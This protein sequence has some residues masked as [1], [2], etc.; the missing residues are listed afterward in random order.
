M[1]N[2][3]FLTFLENYV[4]FVCSKSALLLRHCFWYIELVVPKL[5]SLADPI[6]YLKLGKFEQ[7]VLKNCKC[8]VIGCLK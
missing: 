7:S 6:K 4:G 2:A 8:S 3:C 5:S 1:S